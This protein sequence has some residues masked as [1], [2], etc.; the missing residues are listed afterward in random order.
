MSDR[1][2]VSAILPV[3]NGAEFIA[4]AIESVLNQTY[5]PIECIVVDDGSTD[6]TADVVRRYA[7]DV[8]LLQ[9]TNQRVARARNNGAA[10]AAGR[11]LAFLDADDT[12]APERVERQWEVLANRPEL[13]A[14]VCATQVVDGFGNPTR[15][16]EQSPDLSVEDLL[17]WRSGAV[18]SS[19]NLLIRRETFDE[20]G[21]FD[22]RLT[23]SEDWMMTL[24]LLSR[25]ALTAIPDPLVRYRVHGANWSLSVEAIEGGMMGAFAQVFDDPAADPRHRALR[26]R[27]YANLHRMLAGSYFSKRQWRPFLRQFALSVRSHPSALPYFLALPVRHL[28]RH[29]D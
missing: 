29:T 27:A 19:S 21:G 3:F 24:R 14:V 10:Q 28:R 2:L 22:E 20:V 18:S 16:I 17:L 9:Q 11:L 23:A 7:P 25:G 26:R 4:D 1:P 6:E 5:Q 12:W 8:R 15:V 13:G